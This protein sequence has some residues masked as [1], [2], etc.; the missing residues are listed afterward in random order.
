VR[1]VITRPGLQLD[2][3]RRPGVGTWRAHALVGLILALLFIGDLPVVHDHDRSGVYNE[4][5]ALARLATA[6][7]R[8]S[9]SADL[10]LSVLVCAPEAVST[11]PRAILALVSPTS[12]DPR[13]P[14]VQPIAP[15]FA[16]IG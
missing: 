10:D 6:S 4:E 2:C 16:V 1:D 8:A 12:F 11:A 9:V 7:P 14:P 3:S 5:C 15:F 13:A